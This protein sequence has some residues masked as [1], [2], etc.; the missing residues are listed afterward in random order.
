MPGV[1][2]KAFATLMETHDG[3]RSSKEQ[4]IKD[5]IA[6]RQG[7]VEGAAFA[8]I[9]DVRP[10][11][12]SLFDITL[13]DDPV[14]ELGR[15]ALYRPTVFEGVHGRLLAHTIDE[16]MGPGFNLDLTAEPLHEVRQ[17][18]DAWPAAQA[19]FFRIYMQPRLS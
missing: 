15:Y 18:P 2:R 17:G 3:Q 7:T 12:E 16:I 6:Q 5:L 11:A 8:W 13:P 4:A 9:D 1:T 19:L 10:I 14:M